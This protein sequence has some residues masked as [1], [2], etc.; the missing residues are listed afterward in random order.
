MWDIF[1]VKNIQRF[2]Q[3]IMSQHEQSGTRADIEQFDNV[4]AVDW[5]LFPLWL[6]RVTLDR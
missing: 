6:R 4:A 5:L 2:S 3:L 1:Q